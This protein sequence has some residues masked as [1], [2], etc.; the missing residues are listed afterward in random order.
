ME[1]AQTDLLETKRKS[2]HV[3]W[4]QTTDKFF[5]VELKENSNCTMLRLKKSSP[6]QTISTLIGSVLLDIHQSSKTFNH[7]LLQLVG[8]V[9][10]KSGIKTSQSDS[11]SRLMIPKSTVLQSTHLVNTLQ[12]E[13]RI[14]NCT[15]GTLQ[16][17][18]NQPL[19][20]MQEVSL[21]NSLSIHNKIGLLLPQKMVSKFGKFHKK[22]R[23]KPRHQLLH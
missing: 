13:V 17:W 15:F 5:V 16:I 21:T 7:I 3:P 2:S 19:N 8:T 4:V 11:N 20:M 18:R 6:K 9:G 10:S 1:H 12:Q 23:L 14:R 22:K